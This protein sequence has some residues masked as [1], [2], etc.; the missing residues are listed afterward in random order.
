MIEFIRWHDLS[1]TQ[2]LFHGRGH[3][4]QGYEHVNVDWFAPVALI[5]LYK[6]ED[7]SFL[8]PIAH[9][10]MT[11]L[12]GCQSVQVQYRCRP[13]APRKV[14]LGEDITET[15]V[16]EHTR[17][18]QVRFGRSQNHG[19]FLDMV[20][21][22]DWLA[23]HAR[24]KKVLNLFSYTC[25]FSVAAIQ[26]GASEVVNVDLSKA[27]LAVGRENHKLNQQ[28]LTKVKFQGIDIFKSFGRL[29]KLGPFDILVCDPPSF[30]KGSVNIQR[31]YGKIIRRLPDF[32]ASGADLL[33]CLNSPDL[34][35][36][37]LKA[38][39]AEHCSDCQFIEQLDNPEVF[40]EAHQGKGLK[41][42][43]YKFKPSSV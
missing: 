11:N 19:L 9:Y 36:A 43:H 6:E 14:L 13:M 3:A 1:Q 2:R 30:Q 8:M 27:S 5:T 24:H 31:D 7:A 12:S 15:V 34:D 35:E 16:Q 33:L 10:L 28:D 32:M 21:G 39:V 38:Q 29:K 17:K 22:R 41:V 23:Q 37:F 25:A 4:Y 42:L 20:N 40:K 18:Y 26:G